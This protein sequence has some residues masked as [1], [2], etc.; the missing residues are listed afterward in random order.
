[1][2]ICVLSEY[3]YPDS[4]GGT[5]AVLSSLLRHLKDTYHDLEIE[6]ITSKNLFR[7]EAQTLARSENW[8]G[9][10]ISRLKTPQPRKKSMRRRLAANLL[11]TGAAFRALMARRKKYDLV[12]VVTAPPT[13]PAAARLFSRLT[14]TPYIYLVY[15][16]YLDMALAMNMVQPDSRAV[17]Q[18]HKVQRNWFHGSSK[19]VVLGRC[20]RDFVIGR[21]SIPPEN[22]EV[23]PI[24]ANSDQIKPFTGSTEFR[25][26]ANLDGFVVLYAGN[27]AQYQDFDTLL[28]AASTLKDRKD[29]TFIFVG[30]GAKKEHIV[31]RVQSEK[32]SNVQMFPF[33]PENQL[34]DL[35]AS[36]DI[37]LVTL[38]QEM[39][40]LAVP[41]KFYNILASG[42]PTVA[43][44]NP[45]SEVG[46]VIEE[47]KCGVQIDP[48]D[49]AHLAA[50][51]AELADSPARVQEMGRNA[52]QVCEKYYSLQ[53]VGH[54]FYQVFNDVMYGESDA[55]TRMASV[56]MVHPSSVASP[57]GSRNHSRGESAQL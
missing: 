15:D 29:I 31:S 21:Y 50:T 25:T 47:S 35:L 17:R 5:G 28:D 16:L 56:K 52:R 49:S 10:Q 46:R 1:M 45:I 51:I 34:P 19:V 40:G 2:K 18:M 39:V 9:I 37:S 11:F 23:L 44:V 42:R 24:P 54:R 27:F 12:M 41:S 43:V 20:M 38:E 32:L 57:V 30:D 48:E 3:F 33:V 6:V 22:V 36:A 13:L 14:G 4:T 7:G 55:T 8:D 53:H 26:K